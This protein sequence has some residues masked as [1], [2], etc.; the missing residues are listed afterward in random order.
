MVIFLKKIILNKQQCK[1][2]EKQL[3]HYS[4][5]CCITYENQTDPGSFMYNFF[6]FVLDMTKIQNDYC[7]R[8][9]VL[10]KLSITEV[11]CFTQLNGFQIRL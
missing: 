3:H 10:H 8:Y 1:K 5:K 9:F 4:V 6:L 7:R 11:L 2:E